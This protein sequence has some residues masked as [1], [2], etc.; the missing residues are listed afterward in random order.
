[1]EVKDLPFLSIFQV[2]GAMG[3]AR[4]NYSGIAANVSALFCL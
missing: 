2:A 3:R 1:M 4:L